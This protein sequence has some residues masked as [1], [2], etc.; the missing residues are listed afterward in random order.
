MAKLKLAKKFTERSG[1]NHTQTTGSG[2][3]RVSP[4]THLVS[5]TD[6]ERLRGEITKKIEDNPAKAAGIL[7]SWIARGSRRKDGK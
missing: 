7:Q 4:P 6:I 3:T 2:K 1:P 5:V